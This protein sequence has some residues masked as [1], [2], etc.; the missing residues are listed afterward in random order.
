MAKESTFDRLVLEISPAE[1]SKMLEKLKLYQSPNDAGNLLANEAVEEPHIHIAE[2]TEHLT[3]LDKILLFF[4]SLFL[5]KPKSELIKEKLLH[6]IARRITSRYHGLIDI[7]GKMLLKS[8]Y[9]ELLILEKAISYFG[10]IFSK[11][12]SENLAPLYVFLVSLYSG[13]I[14]STLLETTDPWKMEKKFPDMK[15]HEIRSAMQKAVDAIPGQFTD[16]VRLM[17]STDI[18]LLFILNELANYPIKNLLESFLSIDGKYESPLSINFE[19]LKKLNNLLHEIN[20]LPSICLLDTLFFFYHGEKY[21]G[22]LDAYH[23][24]IS[25]EITLLLDNF[26][27]IRNFRKKVYLNDITALA[28]QNP[29]YEP[30]PVSG[31]EDWLS[32]YKKFWK[33]RI[34]KNFVVYSFQKKSEQLQIEIN[35]YLKEPY[36]SNLVF[37][38]EKGRETVPPVKYARVLKFIEAVYNNVFIP[39]MN[40]YLKILLLEGDFYKKD[41]KQ[42]FTEA[43]NTIL[44]IPDMLKIFDFMLSPEGDIGKQYLVSKND[45]ASQSVL[46]KKTES[47]LLSIDFETETIIKKVTTSFEKLVFILRGILTRQ[48]NSVYDTLVNLTKIDGRNNKEFL[49]NLEKIRDKLERGF[50]L[51]NDLYALITTKSKIEGNATT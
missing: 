40:K 21:T 15:E 43:Y 11:I 9:D 51:I 33:E 32:Y 22:N 39:E 41:N 31:G 17:V 20:D 46:K 27:I 47:I 25:K 5:N 28:A 3:L 44:Q 38:N 26:K 49:I 35:Y 48:Q 1:R 14:H 42:E 10:T 12:V 23:T 45:I 50:C 13:D 24:A 7:S 19:L 6:N 4:K 18:H 16:S 36:Q 8:F 37:I 34:E 29:E 30:I 2:Y